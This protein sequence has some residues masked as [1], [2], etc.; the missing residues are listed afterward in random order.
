MIVIVNYGLGN[1]ASIYNM[2]KKI[3]IESIISSN[4]D[5]IINADKLILPG[6]GSF[7]TGMKNLKEYGFIETL[8]Q[9]VLEDSTPVLGICLGMQ[10][11]TQKG[12]EGGAEGLGWIDGDSV[13]FDIPENSDNLK[14][15]HMKWNTVEIQGNSKLF[16]DPKKERKY[17]FAHSYHIRC[18]NKDDIVC[19]SNYGYDF[20]AAIEK[21]NIFGTQFHPEKSHKYGMEILSNFANLT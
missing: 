11:F 9:K 8:N 15:P 5:D 21:K 16:K 14:I 19:M 4:L 3:G 18:K 1:L 10:L 12:E 2:L 20:A 7:N 6:V 13:K 17:Y